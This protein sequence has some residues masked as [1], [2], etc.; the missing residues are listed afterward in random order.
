MKKRVEGIG[1]FLL[2]VLVTIV[3]AQVLFRYVLRIP[4]PWTEELARFLLVWVTFIG[5]AAVQAD[6]RHLR[7]DWV[8]SKIGPRGNRVLALV[9]SILGL[10]FALCVLVGTVTSMRVSWPYSAASMPKLSMGIFYV[11]LAFCS[12]FM[13]VKS[14]VDI[15]DLLSPPQIRKE[16]PP[17]S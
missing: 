4:V 15:K 14:I 2:A 17:W 1:S 9:R 13:T 11:P 12:L 8:M 5:A 16:V 3:L 6:D 7:I 10:L